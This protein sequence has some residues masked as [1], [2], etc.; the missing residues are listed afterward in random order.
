MVFR[1]K[2]F[3]EPGGPDGRR[4][5]VFP[6]PLLALPDKPGPG[7]SRAVARR[8]HTKLHVM[9][10]VNLAISALNS[11]FF[12]G[13]GRVPCNRVT[14]MDHLPLAQF[15]AVKGLVQRIR[16]FGAPPPSASRQGALAALRAPASGYVTPE[17]GVGEVVD[18]K[19]EALSL[20]S[21]LVAGV[22]LSTQLP[23][24]LRDMVVNFEEWMLRDADSWSG[25]SHL[26]QSMRPYNDPSLHNRA[27]Y[28]RF[29]KHLRQCGILGFSSCVRGRVGAFTVSKKDKIVNGVKVKRQRLVLDCR[30]V[31][32]QFRT[33]PHVELGSLSAVTELELGQDQYLFTSGSDIQDCFYACFLPK[34][35]EEFFCLASDISPE[36]AVEV[37]GENAADF[38]SAPRISPCITV[39]PM[40]FSWSFYL[41]QKLHEG[42]CLDALRIPRSNLILDGYPAPDV[43]GDSVLSMPY[44]DNVHCMA[45]SAEACNQGKDGICDRLADMGFTLHEHEAASLVFP[46]LGGEIDGNRG[47]VRTSASRAWNIILAFEYMTDNVVSPELVQKLLGH[48]MVICVLNR[49]G[50][51]VFRRLYDF[52]EKGGSP[53]RLSREEAEECRVFIGVIPLLVGDLRREWSETITATDASPEGYGICERGCPRDTVRCIGRWNERWRF[54]RLPPEE[55]QPRQRAAGLD[56]FRDLNT[57]FVEG[58]DPEQLEYTPNESFPEVPHS[59]MDRDT[60]H[61]VLMGRWGETGEHIT[62]KEGRA[63]VLAVRRMAR[64]THSRRKRH[65]VIVDSMSL[66]FAATKGRATNFALLRITQQL[67][68]LSLAGDFQLRLRWVPSEVNVADGPSRGIL[69]P[70]CEGQV[71]A[72]KQTGDI[73]QSFETSAEESHQWHPDEGRGQTDKTGQEGE[74]Q[75]AHCANEQISWQTL[76][77]PKSL[78]KLAQS[79]Q[80]SFL[81][82]KSVSTEVAEQYRK[83]FDKY[84]SFCKEHGVA[85][86]TSQNTDIYLVDYLDLLFFEAKG[87]SEAEKTVASVEFFCPHVKG[88][89]SRSRR[90]LKGWRK[91]DPPSSRLPL[92]LLVACGIAMVLLRKRLRQMALM[93]MLCFD[94]YFRP[95]EAFT[96]TKKDCVAPVRGAGPQYSFHAVIVRDI[97]DS[98]PDKVGVFDNTILLN[99]KGRLWIG[100]MI[101]DL[102]RQRRRG[103]DLLFDFSPEDYRKAFASAGK[104]LGLEGIHPYQLRHGGAAEDL[105]SKE[106]D[107]N[108]VKARGRWQTDQSVRRYGK[109]GKIQKLLSLLSPSD[110]AYCRWSL[111]HLEAV[112]KGRTPAR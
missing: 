2:I 94:T 107:F 103:S 73:V 80:L 109:T 81:E 47:E 56:P 92:P 30:Q 59:L 64:S 89:L 37:F 39:L 23:T 21:G 31:N 53:R 57:V 106:R 66:A 60:W 19:L 13:E 78:G 67:S 63:L 104:E 6:L 7:L 5:D 15:E 45:T 105:N 75:G 58:D 79:K 33:P 72:S 96:L 40:G 34:G 111:Q 52:I 61:T 46:T 76:C 3:H 102:A 74:S 25:V 108:A 82:T 8:V 62:L 65:L 54:R 38:V 68:A 112:F 26:T 90:A 11:L 35:L 9:E 17:A 12:G 95:G 41:V 29:L 91:E 18:M 14:S 49:C 16:N 84:K 69:L 50:M 51:C 93:V 4:R 1:S 100:E 43:S 88:H 71:G 86:L 20:P 99:S 48:A 85:E 36:E 87:L 32:L 28:L 98:V 55:W 42:A 10:R 97:A 83:Y 77:S 22:D 70:R 44:C 27:G 110:L 101:Q 24:T